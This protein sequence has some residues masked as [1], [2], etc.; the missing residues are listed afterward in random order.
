MF[1]GLD[2]PQQCADPAPVRDV[3]GFTTVARS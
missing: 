2:L 3:S 1:P